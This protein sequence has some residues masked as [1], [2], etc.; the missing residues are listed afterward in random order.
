MSQR[1][2]RLQFGLRKLFLWTAVVALGL[3]V[4]KMSEMPP[5]LLAWLTPWL[6][7][8][9]VLRVALGAKV[10][11]AASAMIG[12]ILAVSLVF[13]SAMAIGRPLAFEDYLSCFVGVLMFG[14]FG[15]FVAGGVA[16]AFHAVNRLDDLMRTKTDR[17]TRRD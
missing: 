10:A 5:I 6:V 1:P 13:V 3:G 7:L 4:F 9:G 16:Y 11:A 17:D 14:L 15:L 12:V 2:R 8:V